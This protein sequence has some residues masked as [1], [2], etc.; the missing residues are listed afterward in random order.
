MGSV[1]VIHSRWRCTETRGGG[2]SPIPSGGTREITE[3]DARQRKGGEGGRSPRNG[4]AKSAASS[5]SASEVLRTREINGTT[6]E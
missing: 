4:A 2:G 5:Q 3:A 1:S 6:R